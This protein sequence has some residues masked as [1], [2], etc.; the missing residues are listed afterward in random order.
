[1]VWKRMEAV[2]K[3]FM[4]FLGHLKW[5]TRLL[6]VP[7]ITLEVSEMTLSLVVMQLI[8][9]LEEIKMMQISKLIQIWLLEHSP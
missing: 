2:I 9:S 4:A 5:S 3:E 6:E 1:M 8:L 7:G